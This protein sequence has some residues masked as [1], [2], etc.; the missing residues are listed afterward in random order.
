MPSQAALVTRYTPEGLPWWGELSVFAVAKAN[1]LSLKDET[2]SSR[3]P[4]SG[5]PGFALFG[6]RGGRSLGENTTLTLAAENLGDVDYRVHG[7][8]L[9]GPGRNFIFS[10][11]HSF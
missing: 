4:S 9:N 2:D 8:G 5:T 11:D 10:L 6:L 7:S 1:D 3:I